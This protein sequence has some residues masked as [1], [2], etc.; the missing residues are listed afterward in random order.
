MN[1][2]ISSAH[3]GPATA[4]SRDEW[5][6]LLT[7]THMLNGGIPTPENRFNLVKWMQARRIEALGVGSPFVERTREY[8]RRYEDAE[9]GKYYGAGFDQQ[10]VKCEAEVQE[11]IRNLNEI[12]GYDPYLYLDNETPKARYGHLWFV[13]WT[14]DFP[15]WHD[16]DQPFDRWMCDEQKP[17]DFGPEPI[18]YER[19]PYMEIIAAQRA[20]GA[21]ALWAH[22]TSWWKTQAGAFVTNIASELPAHLIA[23]GFIDGLAIMGYD[24]Y[25]ASYLELWMHLLDAGYEV[26]GLAET[27]IGLS[28]SKLWDIDPLLLTYFPRTN[29]PLTTRELIQSL[30]SGRVFASSGPV[31]SL[32]VDGTPMGSR[33]TT[34]PGQIHTVHIMMDPAV[35]GESLGR[36]QLLSNNGNVLWSLDNPEPG[37]H[38]VLFRSDGTPSYVLACVFGKGDLPGSKPDKD[39]KRFAVSNPVYL[40]PDNW[41]PVGPTTTR[42]RIA[43]ESSSRYHGGRIVF[44]NAVGEALEEGS[45]ASGESITAEMPASGRFTLWT[46]GGQSECRYLINANARVMEL[47]RY[48]YRGRFLQ[49]YPNLKPG[50]IPAAAFQL[51][52]FRAAMNTLNV[53]L[54]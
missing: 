38:S 33:L 30:K 15:E 6:S 40:R 41:K 5:R 26:L 9:R 4:N 28:S 14:H 16:Y 10:S 46:P 44:E 7:H 47:Q 25:R 19:R 34:T 36:V 31:I 18:P 27:D 50:S 42:V 8:Y 52:E 45:L 35:A 23:D 12:S 22:P 21:L 32:E 37:Q 29:E 13:G 51:E 2:F 24:P 11:L 3:L 54:R 1:T 17:G 49:D 39:L 43:T 53:A 48:L 20:R